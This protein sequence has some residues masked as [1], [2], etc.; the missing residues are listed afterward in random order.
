M[1]TIEATKL[2]RMPVLVLSLFGAAI[3]SIIAIVGVFHPSTYRSWSFLY[4]V[5]FI[6]ISWGLLKM[7]REAAIAGFIFFLIGFFFNWGSS[8][9]IRDALML[10]LY[11]LAIRGTFAYVRLCGNS[12]LEKQ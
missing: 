9:A 5:L 6:T 12:N 8:Q 4:A 10:P 1:E 3:W 7:R 2:A 11:G